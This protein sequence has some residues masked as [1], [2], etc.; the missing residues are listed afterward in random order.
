[1]AISYVGNMKLNGYRITNT[2][3]GSCNGS[4]IGAN[5]SASTNSAPYLVSWSGTNTLYTANTFDISNLCADNYV[6]T[7][8]DYTGATATTTIT[9]SAFTVPSIDAS[10]TNDDCI[11]DPNKKGTITVT[12]STTTTPT[13]TYELR[14]NNKLLDIYYGDT[15]NTTHSFSGI[16]NGLYTV[17]VMEEK[18][19]DF[20]TK[21]S[22]SGCTAYN[23]NDGGTPYGWLLPNVIGNTWENFIPN[24]PFH[25][26][27]LPGNTGWGPSTAG[28]QVYYELGLL[29]DGTIDTTNPY[30]WFYTGNTLTRKTDLGQD[31]YLGVSALTTEEGNNNVGPDIARTVGNIGKFYYNS[32]IN[33]FVYLW[34]SYGAVIS[35]ITY[36]PRENYGIPGNPRSSNLT[37][38]T[39]GFSITNLSAVDVTVDPSSGNVAATSG[40]YPG[41]G[42]DGKFYASSTANNASVGG[43]LSLCTY[44]NYSWQ[45]TFNATADNDSLY[46][47][48]AAFRDD[49]AKYGPSGVTYNLYLQANGTTGKIAIGVQAGMSGYGIKRDGYQFRNC[50]QGACTTPNPNAGKVTLAGYGTYLTPFSA[51]TGA[52]NNMGAVRVKIDRTGT[53][54]ENF[55]IQFTE[56]MGTGSSAT[57]AIG[58]SNGYNPRYDINFNLLDTSTWSGNT[59]SAYDD[60]DFIQRYDLCKF[61]GSKKIGYGQGSQPS[62]SFY[63]ITFTGNPS[64]QEIIPPDCGNSQGPSNTTTIT[65]TTGTTT[66]IIETNNTSSY[67]STEPNVP[68]VNPRVNV[69]LQTMPSPSVSIV[70]LSKPNVK[71]STQIGNKPVLSVYNASQGGGGEIKVYYGGNNTDMLL[72]N[73]YPKFRIY[74]YITEQEMVATAPVYE[75]IFDVIPSYY[76]SSS[77]SNILSAS[78]FIPWSGFCTG[79]SWE[80]IV[81]PSYL[82]K[83]KTS[84]NDVWIDTATYPPN[85]AVS[86]SQDFY[87]ALVK[88]PPIPV[89]ALDNF[90][91]PLNRPSQLVSESVVVEGMPETTNFSGSPNEAFSSAT[92]RH[93][94][95]SAI[96][97]IPFVT[98]N[99][100]AVSEGVSGYTAEAVVPIPNDPSGRTITNVHN[101]LPTG[102][103]RLSLG[104]KSITFFP[105]T[106]Q[107]GDQLQI[108]YD[109]VGG[110]WA[111]FFTVPETV[112]TTNT[113]IIFEENGYYYVN[114]QKQSLGAVM[115]AINGIIQGDGVNYVKT[116]DTRIQLLESPDTYKSGDT[117]GLFYKTIYMV[118]GLSMNK[119]PQIPINYLKDKSLIDTIR[120]RL[121]NEDGNIVQE[122]NQTIAADIVGAV[123]RT[124]T[125]LPPAP[126][127]YKYRVSITRQ[128]PLLNGESVYA[129]SQTDVVPFEI[130]RN[131]FY[132]PDG[133]HPSNRKG[134]GGAEG[135]NGAY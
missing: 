92:Y 127:N 49:T 110:S 69:S 51:G 82:F 48:L 40:I 70:G 112:T 33:K 17:T 42:E 3:S 123:Y 39:S 131:V 102:D 47:F 63:H 104:N 80:Y 43:M 46:L 55:H 21:P 66:N 118:V 44:N 8:T 96:A 50:F 7:I 11:L 1:M 107:N 121:F 36:D 45:T 72:G 6:A 114:L 78:T 5:I 10:L 19:I 122:L 115:F 113:E 79:S 54:G 85:K 41:S 12:D 105:E 87:M 111:E 81:R 16:E 120:V 30:V 60:Y 88:D 117:F 71:L 73:M 77:Q 133:I 38:A 62:L 108:L 98:V 99:G 83:D 61:L 53:V 125:L 100:I 130:T 132:S 84:S 126:G 25:L 106:V 24:A 91:V 56:T 52:W 18:I 95:R 89:L 74:P 65:A 20:D 134:P 14:K 34:P 35:W 101:F 32:I 27:F 9:L 29:P 26:S 58:Q 59:F 75:A 135:F 37:G 124:F 4:I 64:Q 128:Y 103:Y 76:D 116:S 57:R 68:K 129:T 93:D 28:T 31:W 86:N 109:A 67:S 2:L 119:E 13:Y 97:S 23:F 22:Q 94:I 15:G 90:R